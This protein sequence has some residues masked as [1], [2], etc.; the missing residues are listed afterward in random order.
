MNPV[1]FRWRSSTATGPL[2]KGLSA[3]AGLAVFA[4]VLLAAVG[5]G[6]VL[7]VGIAVLVFAGLAAAWLPRG[8]R[9]RTHARNRTE[10]VI[11]AA[12]TRAAEEPRND[13]KNA[14]DPRS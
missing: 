13:T 5:L 3:L 7:A 12:R 14:Q 9:E 6:L 11:R 8:L 10:V 4:F 1:H 2:A